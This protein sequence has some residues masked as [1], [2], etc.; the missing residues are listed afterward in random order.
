VKNKN[1]I[2]V[3]YL[4]SRFETTQKDHH[5]FFPHLYASF[6]I[7]PYLAC[8]GFVLISTSIVYPKNKKRF[9]HS[10]D[11]DTYCGSIRGRNPI[12]P[13]FRAPIFKLINIT[14]AKNKNGSEGFP[15]KAI[16]EIDDYHFSS[17]I[18]AILRL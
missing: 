7:C 9:P 17:H 4:T 16:E 11:F 1:A 2:I 15:D 18:L 8:S 13:S 6:C 12:N 14:T 10:L 3:F 5:P